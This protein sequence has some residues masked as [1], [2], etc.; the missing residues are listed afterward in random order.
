M[1]KQTTNNKIDNTAAEMPT[2]LDAEQ[3]DAASV[4]SAE[5]VDSENTQASIEGIDFKKLKMRGLPK[6][7]TLDRASIIMDA[8]NAITSGNP[9]NQDEGKAFTGFTVN[10]FQ[11]FM[12][13][14]N[15]ENAAVYCIIHSYN[16]RNRNFQAFTYL[17]DKP[18]N[19]T[20]TMNATK[21]LPELAAD[22]KLSGEQIYGYNSRITKAMRISSEDEKS[23][24][25]T[26]SF[27]HMVE[28]NFGVDCAFISR[29][30]CQWARKNI[31][32]LYSLNEGFDVNA[33]PADT[34]NIDY[35][36]VNSLFDYLSYLR[37]IIKD[38]DK[39]YSEGQKMA[40]QAIL[41][42]IGA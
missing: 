37:L 21:E 17:H 10:A 4:D 11:T 29:P 33:L 36:E 8:V 2:V 6:G 26:M 38:A 41:T 13:D 3:I 19:F 1:A 7:I 15:Y 34:V 31:S 5:K 20:C 12:G 27:N 39:E 24:I 18:F 28:K 40:A 9:D 23:L 14:K 32:A 35:R 25:G 30:D 22:K 16:G 42:K